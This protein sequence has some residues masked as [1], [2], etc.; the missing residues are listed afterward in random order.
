MPG[1][2][3]AQGLPLLVLE[4]I[5]RR[6]LPTYESVVDSVLPVPSSS[7]ELLPLMAQC[8]AW[9]HVA[10][11]MFY[12]T[13]KMWAIGREVSKQDKIDWLSLDDV[14]AMG[15]Q[16]YVKELHIHV[17]LSDLAEPW[18]TEPN[19]AAALAGH[20]DLSSVRRLSIFINTNRPSIAAPWIQQADPAAREVVVQ[21]VH[22]LV[23]QLRRS[24]RSAKCIS[25]HRSQMS[26][27]AVT[28][29]YGSCLTEQIPSMIGRDT[30]QLLLDRLDVTKDMVKVLAQATLRSITI[31]GH[32]GSQQ[33]VEL[34]RRNAAT[35]EKL[36]LSRI[37][38]FSVVKM[39]RTGRG[40]VDTLVYPR[41]ESLHI[42]TL[43]GP[44]KTRTQQPQIDPFP[45]LHT[46]VS[47]GSFPF[48]SAAIFDGGRSHIRH[49]D[50]DMD[51]GLMALFKEHGLAGKGAFAKMQ[52]VSLGWYQSDSAQRDVPHSL[53][54]LSAGLSP[55]TRVIR[56]HAIRTGIM[57][58]AITGLGAATSLEVLDLP[59]CRLNIDQ[60]IALFSAC[61]RLLKAN[62]LFMEPRY[63]ASLR[64]PSVDVLR[65][66]QENNRSPTS[67]IRALGIRGTNCKTVR[68]AGEFIVL[69][70]DIFSGTLQRVTF[71]RNCNRYPEKLT[72]AVEYAKKRPPYKGRQIHA[73]KFDV[74]DSW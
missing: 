33:H 46:L 57:T 9:R 54:E 13:A 64:M 74:G 14:A 55:A 62:I 21:N 50:L 10:A 56:I 24:L 5:F 45:R 37:T 28:R 53:V 25:I 18:E 40:G 4:S 35:L 69:L 12:N 23:D 29:V 41:L 72:R 70:A 26:R 30:T 22:A 59:R 7:R 49:L 36:W 17:L 66:Y 61:P 20:G 71:S 44:R 8:R 51:T 63:R 47:R 2:S 48:Y 34:V 3:V 1:C 52:F 67:R 43:I 68:R 27:T 73:V 31:V 60:C 11:A 32:T 16:A 42:S 19:V 15:C 39:T 65:E 58:D 38:Q 6:V